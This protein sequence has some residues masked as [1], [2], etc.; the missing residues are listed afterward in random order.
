MNESLIVFAVRMIELVIIIGLFFVLSR[1]VNYIVPKIKNSD[2]VRSS[3]FLNPEEY[4]PDEQ[5]T[6]LKQLFYLI[7]ITLFVI[8]M[9]YLIMN[10]YPND[11]TFVVMDIILSLYLAYQMDTK[12]YTNKFLLFFVIPFSSI[13]YMLFTYEWYSYLLDIVHAIVYFYF[14]RLYYKKFYEYTE[15]NSLGI[16][17]MLLFLI[18]FISFLITIPVEKVSPLDSMEMVSNA[19]TSNGYAVLGKTSLGKIN[20]IILV[21]SGFILSGVASATLAVSIVMNHVNSK[22]DRLE[23]LAKKNKKN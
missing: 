11:V 18:V 10:I 9:L 7:M 16:T 15:T 2:R 14:I 5:I 12:S 22:F 8:N 21:W 19:F 20:A 3:K 6:E 23:E 1:T 4:L 13:M 17:I